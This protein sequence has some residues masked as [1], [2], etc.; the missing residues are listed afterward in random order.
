MRE[1]WPDKQ[2]KK[3]YLDRIDREQQLYDDLVARINELQSNLD[4]YE[5]TTDAIIQAFASSFTTS[6][7]NATNIYSES[8]SADVVNILRATFSEIISSKITTDRIDVNT[9]ANISRAVVDEIVSNDSATFKDVHITGELTLDNVLDLDKLNVNEFII[10]S[11]EATTSIISNLTATSA[12]ITNASITTENVDTSNITDANITNAKIT[13]AEITE[14]DFDNISVLSIENGKLAQTVQGTVDDY[15]VELPAFENGIYDVYATD[16]NNNPLWAVSAHNDTFGHFF[17]SW[18]TLTS[19]HLIS[20]Y[21]NDNKLYIKCHANNVPNLVY[22]KN[23]SFNKQYAPTIYDT[24]DVSAFREWAIQSRSGMWVTGYLN[25]EHN[26]NTQIAIAELEL[27]PSDDYTNTS[28][29]TVVYNGD[30]AKVFKPY[31]P[32]QSLNTDDDVEF[33]NLT[34]STLEANT[35]AMVSAAKKVISVDSITLV[36]GEIQI[37]SG[38]SM[39]AVANAN[40]LIYWNGSADN[41]GTKVYP[42]TK[43]GNVDHGTWDAGNVTTPKLDAEVIKGGRYNFYSGPKLADNGQHITPIDEF[44]IDLGINSPAGGRYWNAYPNDANPDFTPPSGATVTETEL[45][46]TNVD[47]STLADYPSKEFGSGANSGRV[48]FIKNSILGYPI[49]SINPTG[50]VLATPAKS[51][52]PVTNYHSTSVPKYIHYTR[53]ETDI[54][55]LDEFEENSLLIETTE[56]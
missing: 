46:P 5:D 30:T 3:E 56:E 12:T 8:I 4:N 43:L 22:Y 47:I 18:S 52:S 16:E 44:I 24:L 21:T 33:E 49:V 15:Y 25:A 45:Y 27:I 32:D 51:L 1:L 20:F 36:N 31:R 35:Y 39:K 54:D 2:Q 11:L 17:W 29:E 14:G 7:L 38:L 48:W 55:G 28:S 40:T 23:N 42:L 6:L 19:G 37:G 41:N 26:G 10:N 53:A 9:I 34:I 13:N 50:V